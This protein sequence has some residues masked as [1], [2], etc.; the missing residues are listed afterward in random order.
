MISTLQ[1]K[2]LQLRE[3]MRLAEDHTARKKVQQGFEYS[4]LCLCAGHVP[5]AP[6]VLL[7]TVLHPALCPRTDKTTLTG[8]LVLWLLFGFGW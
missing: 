6:P 2:K 8:S 1:M 4:S 3:S 7:V 5:L